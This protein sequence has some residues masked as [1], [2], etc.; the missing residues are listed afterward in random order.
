[1]QFKK[2][3]FLNKSVSLITAVGLTIFGGVTATPAGARGYRHHSYDQSEEF[4]QVQEYRRL[5]KARRL[6]TFGNKIIA[7]YRVDS[8]RLKFK[9]F[10]LKT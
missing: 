10:R 6:Q 3:S 5:Q 2:S 9:F 1:M 8:D 7:K 4:H